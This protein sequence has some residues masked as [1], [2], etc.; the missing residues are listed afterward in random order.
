[1][2]SNNF[3]FTI[4][5]GDFKTAPP[6]IDRPGVYI[7]EGEGGQILYVGQSGQMVSRSKAHR[8]KKWGGQIRSERYFACS[9]PEE[10]L[11]I[12][13][14]L[15]LRY[16]PRHNRAIKLGLRKDGSIYEIQFVRGSRKD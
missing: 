12:E 8:K 11:V 3:P 6:T 15:I 5:R 14:V 9:D 1:M 16:R 13:A 4:Q 2:N 10:R 7:L